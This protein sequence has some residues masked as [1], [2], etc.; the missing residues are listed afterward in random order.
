MDACRGTVVVYDGFG[1]I[2]T[3]ALVLA[4]CLHIDPGDGCILTLTVWK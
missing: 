2:G 3:L 4:K 1:P